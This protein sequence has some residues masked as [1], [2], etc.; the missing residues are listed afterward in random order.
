ME[1]SS[2]RLGVNNVADEEPPLASE[3]LGFEGELHSSRGR[4]V[5]LQLNK[6]FAPN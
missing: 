1:D 2:I 3:S 4:Y 6:R 5:Y